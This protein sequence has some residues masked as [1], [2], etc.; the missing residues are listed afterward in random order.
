MKP[1]RANPLTATETYMHG[2]KSRAQ[3]NHC[4]GNGAFPV[5]L[6]TLNDMRRQYSKAVQPVTLTPFFIKA[7]A[8]TVRANPGANRILFQRFPFRRRIVDF[9]VVDVN[10]PVVRQVDGQPLIFIGVVRGADNL[11]IAEIQDELTRMQRE[12]AEESPYLQKMAKLR[13]APR[14]AIA[15]YH[16][17]MSRSPS[18]YLRNAGTCGVTALDGMAGGH[19]FPIGPSTAVFAIGG[20]GDEVVARD[21]VP[22]VRR[23]LQV[24]LA[25]DNYVASGP[26]GLQLALMFQE[27]LES[28]SFV[29]SELEGRE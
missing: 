28:C 17:L 15:L 12:P 26:E 1:F 3:H 6:T 22:V 25:L 14:F 11:T 8:L 20:A 2:L 19:F 10:V 27:L 5:E 24:A 21:G 29:T 23:V 9:D 18:F 7:V 16:W 13:H 4:L